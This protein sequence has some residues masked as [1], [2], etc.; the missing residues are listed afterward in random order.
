MIYSVKKSVKFSTVLLTAALT[1]PWALTACSPAEE[2]PSSA[3]NTTTTAAAE[4]SGEAAAD[5]DAD[6][7]RTV[8]IDDQEITL[9]SKPMRIAV[10]TPEA[11]SLV[12]PLAG[13]ERV[14]VTSEMNP[15]DEE[16]YALAQ[17]VP[18]QIKPGGSLDPE[19]VLAADPDLAIVSARFDTEQD[20][21]T[22]LENFGVPVVNFDIDGWG[23]I[24]SIITHMDYV[25]Q[26]VGAEDEAAEAIAE[27][28][29]TRSEVTT[30][31]EA[32]KVLAMMQRGPRQ[33]IMPESS[34]M[35]GLIREAGGEPLVDS[36]GATGTITA[37]PEQVLAM[38]P[39]IIIIQDYLG[40]GRDDFAD[41]LSNP[42]LADVP[43]IADDKV[44]YADTRTTGFAAGTDITQGL[45]E[46]SEMINS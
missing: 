11:A 7:P 3:D 29:E 23:D 1:V 17:D 33:M 5:S 21:I 34:M 14:V 8:T 10:I 32:P 40:K 35:S 19:Q 46:V 41:F 18:T 26:L 25:G 36:L 2:N 4:V 24:D 28:Q 39:D 15:E 43:A 13:A 44:F 12:L 20:T 38:N 30:P 37:D 45:L 31:E 16:L 9:E 27:I 22:I 42:A 6:Y